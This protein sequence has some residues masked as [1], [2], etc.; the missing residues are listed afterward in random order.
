LAGTVKKK[1][2]FGMGPSGE[3]AQRDT[4]PL[5]QREVLSLVWKLAEPICAVEGIELIH[6]EYQREPAGRVLRIYIDRSEGVTVADCTNLSRQLG[7][8]LDIKLEDEGAYTLEV[9][10]PGPER[11]LSRPSDFER[12]TGK[13]VKIKTVFSIGGQK[14]FTGVLSGIMDGKI[15][16]ITAT[17]TV[18]I[19][20][21]EVIRARLLNQNGDH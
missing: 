4:H 18:V 12:F 9:S 14:N 13:T 16:L 20:F 8:L 15:T 1:A 11:P 19:P 5:K 17:K 2:G 6:V 10:S 3:D 21:Q 7:D